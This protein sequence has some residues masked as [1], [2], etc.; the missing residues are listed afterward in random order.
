MH[1]KKV[2]GNRDPFVS[3]VSVE[4][5]VMDACNRTCSFCPHA[6][7]KTY[8]NQPKW[9][10][11]LELSRE[12]AKQ[13]A[14]L[15]YTGRISFSG[16]GEPL[17]NRNVYEHIKTYRKVL[18]DNTIEMNSNGDVLDVNRTKRL[19]KAGLTAIYVNLYDDPGQVETFTRMFEEAGV[20]MYHLRLHF[21][22]KD[23]WGLTLN[24]RSG[25]VNPIAEPMVHRCHYPF[26]KMFID[27]DGSVPFCANDWGR[28]IIVGN[29]L[30]NSIKDIWLSDKMKEIRLRLAAKD[31]SHHPCSGCDVDGTLHG[32]FSFTAL[33]DYYNHNPAK[34]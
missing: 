24:N 10:M 11:S 34:T 16:Y 8:P 3:L 33:M 22:K 9:Q 17:M 1:K 12:I 20:D 25:L 29:V 21:D 30:E 27:W 14:T 26:Y 32:E 31:R 2:S 18:P 5:N 7:P 23:D 4:I 13:L 15:E 19:F 28:N 6:D